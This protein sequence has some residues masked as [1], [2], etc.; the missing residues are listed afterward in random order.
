MLKVLTKNGGE[1]KV[2]SPGKA[3]VPH[4][5]WGD[6]LLGRASVPRHSLQTGGYRAPTP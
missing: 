4:I 6:T 5:P 3:S 1:V 2:K